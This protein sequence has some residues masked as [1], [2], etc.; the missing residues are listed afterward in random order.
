MIQTLEQVKLD[1]FNINTDSLFKKYNIKNLIIEKLKKN[2]EEKTEEIKS[3]LVDFSKPGS[4]LF[5]QLDNQDSFEINRGLQNSEIKE[6]EKFIVNNSTDESTETKKAFTELADVNKIRDNTVVT[7][8]SIVDDTRK[9]ITDVGEYKP[10][11]KTMKGYF[12]KYIKLFTGFVDILVREQ[13]AFFVGII[14][15]VLSIITNF[16]EVTRN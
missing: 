16:I 7:L 4:L 11:D 9:L 13:R 1:D 2:E 10:S 8:N 5:E 14:L 12:E 3:K 6:Y 15:I